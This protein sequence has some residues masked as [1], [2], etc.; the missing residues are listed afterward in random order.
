MTR[1]LTARIASRI[2]R[3]PVSVRAE[4]AHRFPMAVRP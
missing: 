3:S 2:S 1:R 4:H